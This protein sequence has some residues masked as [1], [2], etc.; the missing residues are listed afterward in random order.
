MKLSWWPI[1]PL[2]ITGLIAF[3]FVGMV[4]FFFSQRE[5]AHQITCASNIKQMSSAL[6]QY[7]LDHDGLTPPAATWCNAYKIYTRHIIKCP[8]AGGNVG[9]AY[10]NRLD[11]VKSSDYSD[12]T[13]VVWIYD[14]TSSAYNAHDNLTSIPKPGR[15]NFAGSSNNYGFLDGHVKWEISPPA[16]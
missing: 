9:Y 6:M 8:A 5:M 13:T 1:V 10:N 16:H 2:T 11:H 7:E 14:S 15:H 3:W 4:S 12:P